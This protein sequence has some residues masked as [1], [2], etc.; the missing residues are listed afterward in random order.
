MHPSYFEA[1]LN[2]DK[3]FPNYLCAQDGNLLSDD[4]LQESVRQLGIS[5]DTTV[6]VYGKGDAPI[7]SACRA[8]WSLMYAGVKDVRLLNG[9][10][11]E[12][13]QVGGSI[14]DK[15]NEYD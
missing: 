6:V 7:M 15:P 8:V 10:F 9:G 3:Y 4:S 13:K 2:K 11:K 1:G 12:W 14:D 5:K